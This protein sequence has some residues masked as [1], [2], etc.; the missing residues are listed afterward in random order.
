MGWLFWVQGA[1]SAHHGLIA[2]PPRRRLDEERPARQLG[3][4]AV[5]LLRPSASALVVRARDAAPSDAALPLLGRGEA[6]P[7]ARDQHRPLPHEVAPVALV[8]ATG[9]PSDNAAD[10]RV[11]SVCASDLS[12]ASAPDAVD[13]SDSLRGI[14]A[15]GITGK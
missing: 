3:V 6:G 11:I 1:M 5:L 4:G 8:A 14:T 13:G 12:M 15:R 9:R 2:M 7:A 10:N